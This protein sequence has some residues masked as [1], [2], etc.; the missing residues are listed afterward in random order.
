MQLTKE[1]TGGGVDGFLDFVGIPA[2]FGKAVA[3]ANK[4]C[5]H[6]STFIWF[7]SYVLVE[8]LVKLLRL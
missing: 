5:V 2:T 8:G 3:S 4:V 6:S 7:L 1:K